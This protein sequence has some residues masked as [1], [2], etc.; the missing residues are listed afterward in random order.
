MGFASLRILGFDSASTIEKQRE[1]NGNE[2]EKKTIS[3]HM[4]YIISSALYYANLAS[5]TAALPI[6]LLLTCYWR[7]PQSSCPLSG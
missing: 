1:G 2:R 5:F 6:D 3:P 4:A 7:H